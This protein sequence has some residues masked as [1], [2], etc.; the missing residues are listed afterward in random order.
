MP[1][2][3]PQPVSA[4]SRPGD[5]TAAS[6]AKHR[7]LSEPV[8]GDEAERAWAAQPGRE[9]PVDPALARER[10]PELRQRAAARTDLERQA[11]AHALVAWSSGEAARRIGR[12]RKAT[13]NALQR[14]KRKLSGQE[15]GEAA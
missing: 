2:S 15:N 7:P 1:L 4:A 3:V 11:L 9:D 12:L 8:R 5:P 10:L 6:G 13:D 14:A